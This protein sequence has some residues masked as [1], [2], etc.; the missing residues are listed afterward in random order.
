MV[1]HGTIKLVK[2]PGIGNISDILT[3]AIDHQTIERL[4]PLSKMEMDHEH[5]GTRIMDQFNHESQVYAI[6]HFG[7]NHDTWLWLISFMSMINKIFVLMNVLT[8]IL[9]RFSKVMVVLNMNPE[10]MFMLVVKLVL[11][12]KIMLVLTQSM[13]FARSTVQILIVSFVMKNKKSTWSLKERHCWNFKTSQNS[14][15][16]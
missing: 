14:R 3:K 6:S 9:I 15:I 1:K 12:I 7:G 4:L 13:V 16:A 11:H 8:I 2:M 10:S 5:H